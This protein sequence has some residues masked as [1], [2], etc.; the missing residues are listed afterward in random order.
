MAQGTEENGPH[1]ET[2][3]HQKDLMDLVKGNGP[4]QWMVC[5]VVLAVNFPDGANNMSIAFMAPNVD[6][7]CARPPGINMTVE[8]W[9]EIALPPN[10]P[11]CSRYRYINISLASENSSSSRETVPCESWEYDHSIYA[12]SIVSQWNLVCDRAWL[13]SVAKSIFAAGFGRKPLI[14]ACN[15]LAIVS[16]I[17]CI[18]STSFHMFAI[19][20][21][22]VAAGLTGCDHAAS[23][24]MIEIVSPKYRAPYHVITGMAWLAGVC[25]LPLIALWLRN[26]I[27]IKIAIVLPSVFILSIWW[28]LPE[29]PRWLLAH[30]KTEESLKILS[31]A[32]KTNGLKIS[33]VKL[34]EM[35]L[36]LKEPDVDEKPRTN[37]LQLFQAEIRMRTLLIWYIWVVTAFVFYGIAY[38]TNELAGDPFVNFTIFNLIDV[39][40]SLTILCYKGRRKP[41]AACLACAGVA[42]LL[43][44]PIPADLMWLRTAVSLMGK[45]C[46]SATFTVLGLFTTEIFPTI[47]R[48]TG[49]GSASAVARIGAILAPFV[50]E[51]GRANHPV[52]PQI[53]FGVLSVSAGGLALLLPETSNRSVPDTVR[54]AAQISRKK[55]SEENPEKTWML[56]DFNDG[57][58]SEDLVF[59]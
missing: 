11:H 2:G 8:Q 32:A 59:D 7:W 6:H 16:G 33:D 57:S 46:I 25:H 55:D 56:K 17:S 9:K 12:S 37:C 4:W 14:L 18:F 20:R 45:F 49:L 40:A 43:V 23:V 29:S 36:S 13:V 34:R 44:Y 21:F 53:L 26:W 51:L 38:N 52:F 27:Y 22:F 31:K 50:R 24:L 42:C 1:H 3:H 5:A 39:P 41:L 28:L 35:V 15:I 47:L 48:I 10:D 54:E 19:S 58:E 30:G